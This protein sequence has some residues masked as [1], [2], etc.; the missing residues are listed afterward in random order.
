MAYDLMVQVRNRRMIQNA[1]RS[2]AVVSA[3]FPGAMRDHILEETRLV[4]EAS[5]SKKK[6]EKAP[7]AEFYVDSTVMFA[8][9]AGF[10][11]WSS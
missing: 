1:A 9:I 3:M 5:S 8:D 7:M 10:T 6:K 4:G 11:A 2:R